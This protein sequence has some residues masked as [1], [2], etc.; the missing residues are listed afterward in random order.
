MTHIAMLWIRFSSR[1]KAEAAAIRFKECPKVH[2]WGNHGSEAYII[3]AVDEGEKFWSDYVGEHPER[4]FGGVEARIAYI[5]GLHKPEDIRV[6]QEKI[7][8]DISPCGSVCQT[9]PIYCELCLGCP[10]LELP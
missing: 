1:D 5:D 8:G 2:F 10:A 7:K 9:C 3:I 4:S 6:S